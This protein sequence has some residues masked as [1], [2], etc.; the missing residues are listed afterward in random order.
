[1]NEVSSKICKSHFV[2]VALAGWILL[3]PPID[4]EHLKVISSSPLPDW[5]T[6]LSFDTA[7]E[8]N[9]YRANYARDV[10]AET[11]MQSDL[12][13]A[14]QTD[15]ENGLEAG[16]TIKQQRLGFQRALAALCLA[17]NDPSLKRR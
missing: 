17:D 1:V 11:L 2:A 7:S 10:A 8:C 15:H 14:Y 16:T 12:Q 13:R 5:E 3:F 9:K 6:Y 4:Y